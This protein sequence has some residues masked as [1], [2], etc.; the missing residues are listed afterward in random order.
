[1][2]SKWWSLL[3]GGVMLAATL[4]VVIAPL[5]GLGWG[6]PKNVSSY[7]GEVD[8]LFHIILFVTGF[9]FILTEAILV[10]F[11]FAFAG[12]ADAPVHSKPVE[13]GPQPG[14]FFKK[15]SKPLTP[16]IPDEHRLEMVWTIIPGIILLILAVAQIQ[17]WLRIKDRNWM[18]KPGE[19]PLQMEVS[20]RQFEWRVRY[21][22]SEHMELWKIE[23][24]KPDKDPRILDDFKP[25]RYFDKNSNTWIDNAGSQEDDLHVV[26]EVHTW[27]GVRVLVY[28]TTRDV[29]H[30][31]YLPNLRLKQDAL[32]GKVIPVWFEATEPNTKFNEDTGQW[33][34]GYDFK[35]NTWGNR[36]QIWEL[37]C[38]ELCG[39]GHYKMQGRLYAHETKE[40]FLEW[41]KHAEEEQRRSKP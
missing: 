23:S 36:T 28:L 22:S 24:E 39:W 3:F 38:A 41:L 10:Y 4:S 25:R 17:T 35:K 37:V 18:P 11:M 21:P 1:M 40:D 5:P 7:G 2:Q 13:P 20:A 31:F 32:P 9:F 26:N 19:L 29:I 33:E 12:R 15:V 30:S 6:L 8:L 14:D 16:W 34:D 27:K